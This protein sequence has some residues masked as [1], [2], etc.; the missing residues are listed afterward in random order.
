MISVLT[1][2][3][4]SHSSALSLKAS[5]KSKTENQVNNNAATLVGPIM[6]RSAIGQPIIGRHSGS[7][8]KGFAGIIYAIPQSPRVESVPI[9]AAIEDSLYEYQILASDANGDS[10]LFTHLG[11]SWLGWG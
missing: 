7:S 4:M 5:D 2:I 10:I 3:V 1:L 8:V 9:T 11:P 6:H